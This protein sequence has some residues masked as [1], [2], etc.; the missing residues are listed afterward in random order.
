MALL[1]SG[2]KFMLIRTPVHAVFRHC[3]FY[4][5]TRILCDDQSETHT[6]GEKMAKL[7]VDNLHFFR[8][9][10]TIHNVNNIV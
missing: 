8:T 4:I 7:T 9:I 10:D 1:V 6:G 2:H 3:I 5:Y